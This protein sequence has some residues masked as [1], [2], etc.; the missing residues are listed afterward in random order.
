MKKTILFSTILLGSLVFAQESGRKIGGSRDT[1]GCLNSAGYT[2]SHIKKECIQS[3]DQKIK[4]VE[5]ET[6][7]KT[8]VGNTG[9]IFS[10]DK[11]KAE[12]FIGKSPENSMILSKDGK[13]SAWKNGEYALVPAKKGYELRKNNVVIYK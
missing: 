4:L 11:K 13:E 12:I 1:H 7:G 5:L 2:Y 6:P 3:W 9:V 8:W 10:K